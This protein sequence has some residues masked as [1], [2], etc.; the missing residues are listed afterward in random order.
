VVKKRWNV[1]QIALG[2]EEELRK[3]LDCSGLLARLL[4]RRGIEGL[5]E[6]Q[7]FLHPKLTH[8]HDPF[9]LPGMEAAARRIVRAVQTGEKVAIFGDYDVD[10]VSATCLMCEFFRFIDFPVTYRLPDRLR[11][12][13][14][15]SA[16]AVQEFAAAGVSLIVTVDNGSSAVEEVALAAKLGMDVVITDHHQPPD[17]LPRAVALVN[18][19]LPES[20]YPFKDLAGV[21]VAFK[22]VWALAQRLSKQTKL[23]QEFRDFLMQSLAFVALGT[24]SDVVPLRDE[25][26]VLAKFGLV[27]LEQARQPGLRELVALALDRSPEKHLDASHIGFRIGP[28]INAVGRL[29]KAEKAARLLLTQDPQEAASLAAELDRENM[30]RRE[31]EST[32]AEEARARVLE[33][34]DLERERAIVLVG[35]GWHSGVI[36]IVASRLVE[37]FHRPTL[38]LSLEGDECKGSARSIP[39]VDIRGALSKCQEHLL[40]FGGHEMAAGCRADPA[41]L[42]QLRHALNASIELAPSEMIPEVRVDE[43]VCLEDLTPETLE[44]LARLAPHGQGNPSPSFGLEGVEVVGK[45]RVMG[46]GGKHLAFHVRQDRVVRRAVAFGK[47]TL[48][49]SVSQT[50]AR[51]SLLLS[52]RLSSWQ[53][54]SEVELHVREL[55]VV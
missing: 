34:V 45:P 48:F 19:W 4:V 5:E 43:L 30:R 37:E 44:E 42:E 35:E 22:V 54:R 39:G 32:I 17:D 11:E 28:R 31:I 3:E 33:T 49:P 27:A 47:G 14:G 7:R 38:L 15:L 10:G 18:P 13:Y 51:V 16:T 8:L 12:G 25:N 36:G 29:G 26:R 23:S 24:I 46:A 40:G 20:V 9:Q 52:P 41:A 2:P 53:G 6:A 50:G 1:G 21:G 55:E